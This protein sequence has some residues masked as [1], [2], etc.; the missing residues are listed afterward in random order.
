MQTITEVMNMYGIYL[1]CEKCG[2]IFDLNEGYNNNLN[3]KIA[4]TTGFQVAGHTL[5]FSGLCLN[6]QSLKEV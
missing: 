4:V 6:C 3:Q 2:A 1:K 5:D